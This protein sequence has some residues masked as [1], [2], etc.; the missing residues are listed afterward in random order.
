SIR[1]VYETDPSFSETHWSEN[2]DRVTRLV[3]QVKEEEL[4]SGFSVLDM[5]ELAEMEE[6]GFISFDDEE[7]LD[8]E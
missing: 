1:L 6:V 7:E 3:M 8:E 2:L 5:Q 4:L